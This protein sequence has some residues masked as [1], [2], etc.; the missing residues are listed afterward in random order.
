MSEE[1]W[2][3]A[4][5][6]A[7][8]H[9]FCVNPT[10]KINTEDNPGKTLSLPIVNPSDA[11]LDK[12]WTR[13]AELTARYHDVNDN[14][15]GCNE[16]REWNRTNRAVSLKIHNNRKIIVSMD[17]QACFKCVNSK[18]SR[19]CIVD[20][21][22][23]SCRSCRSIKISCDRKTQFVF[24]LTKTE[25]F[26]TFDQFM[27]V[28]QNKDRSHLHKYMRV[29]SRRL[30]HTRMLGSVGQESWLATFTLMLTFTRDYT[31]ELS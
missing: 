20:E 4:R 21:D 26:P 27:A 3:I 19:L 23:P 7:A 17:I 9:M 24:D 11:I 5:M 28:Y 10:V 2:H 18:T 1:S 25:F 16:V 12:F 31:V 15:I 22:Q 13:V 14:W 6:A 29:P 30:S 8:Q